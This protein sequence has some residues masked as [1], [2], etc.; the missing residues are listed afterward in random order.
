MADNIKT[1]D[2]MVKLPVCKLCGSHPRPYHSEP[3]LISCGAGA[4]AC[5]FSENPTN[6]PKFTKQQWIAIMGVN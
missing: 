4:G 5:A 2:G 6:F 1:S 3:H